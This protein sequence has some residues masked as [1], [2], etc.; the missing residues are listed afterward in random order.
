MCLLPTK[1]YVI[2]LQKPKSNSLKKVNN[3]N[4]TTI[5]A[6][7]QANISIILIDNI[8]HRIGF[9]LTILTLKDT[10]KNKNMCIKVIFIDESSFWLSILLS[11]T[12]RSTV[13]TKI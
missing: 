9:F 1:V 7:L 4:D 2:Y 5:N 13:A 3:K 11:Q 12:L 6:M 10:T 8:I